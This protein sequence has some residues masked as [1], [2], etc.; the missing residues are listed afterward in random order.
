MLEKQ[1]HM[2]MQPQYKLLSSL[3]QVTNFYRLSVSSS[4]YHSSLEYLIMGTTGLVDS[5]VSDTFTKLL[6]WNLPE[7]YILF[8]GHRKL[9][10]LSG[11]LLHSPPYLSLMVLLN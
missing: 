6:L 5:K 8:S 10:L 4:I 2:S 11:L 3:H 1:R 7:G 9:R